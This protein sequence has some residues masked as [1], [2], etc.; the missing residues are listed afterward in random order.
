MVDKVK[1]VIG[2]FYQVIGLII[3]NILTIIAL[4]IVTLNTSTMSDRNILL[5]YAFICLFAFFIMKSN[6][7]KIKELSAK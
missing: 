4:C 7:A 1:T 3:L 6:N 2:N 5:S